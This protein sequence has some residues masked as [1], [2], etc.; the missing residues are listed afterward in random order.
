MAYYM[1]LSAKIYSIYLKY[2]APEDIVVYSI[3]EVMI[4]ATSYLGTYHMTRGNW[5]EP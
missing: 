4:D 3:D 5:L 1:E 2:I